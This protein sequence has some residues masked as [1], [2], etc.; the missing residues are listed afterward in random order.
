MKK[1]KKSANKGNKEALKQHQD[2]ATGPNN[3]SSTG[4]QVQIV[5]ANAVRPPQ[6]KN[7]L[8][9]AIILEYLSNGFCK[10]KA[11]MVCKPGVTYVGASAIGRTVFK[12]P[13][14]KE[15]ITYKQSE[16]KNN[17]DI[18]SH[19]ILRE[20]IT[21]SFSDITDY[22]DLT[23]EELK[24]LPPATRR[25][26]E[27]YEIKKETYK[28]REGKTI[29]EE[30]VKIKLHS[31]PKF[32]EMINKNIGFYNLDNKQKSNTINLNNVS[33]DNLNVLLQVATELKEGQTP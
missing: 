1:D 31:K 21:L 25:C 10:V 22:I 27:S 32:I 17:V 33:V 9:K 28:N 26:I 24:E 6:P 14:N 3:T 18:D 13:A 8:H 29:T 20:L 15:Y 4:A 30:T 2:Q 23:T 11:V 7:E 12:D 19:N 5:Q 16:L